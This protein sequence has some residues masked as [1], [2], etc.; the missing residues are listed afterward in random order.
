MA[1]RQGA[2]H[3]HSGLWRHGIA[4]RAAGWLETALPRETETGSVRRKPGGAVR[5]RNRAGGEKAFE[6]LVDAG[7]NQPSGSPTTKLPAQS[8]L[9]MI[10]DCCTRAGSQRGIRSS[11][12][13]AKGTVISPPWV[14][15]IVNRE[16]VQRTEMRKVVQESAERSSRAMDREEMRRAEQLNQAGLSIQDVDRQIEKAAKAAAAGAAFAVAAGEAGEPMVP[17]PGSELLISTPRCAK[18]SRPGRKA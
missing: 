7:Q 16:R 9:K 11:G 3:A 1:K 6:T 8:F 4:G 18:A 12:E 15:G 14:R 17:H 2:R 10:V 13:T 5:R